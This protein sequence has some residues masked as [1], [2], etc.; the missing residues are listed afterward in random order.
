MTFKEFA[1]QDA[2]TLQATQLGIESGYV[3]G[4]YLNDQEILCRHLH[5][6]VARWIEDYEATT[7]EVR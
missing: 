2:N 1:L 7:V 3:D 6:E 5:H 4:F